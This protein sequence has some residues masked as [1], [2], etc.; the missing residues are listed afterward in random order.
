MGGVL[1]YVRCESEIKTLFDRSMKV[2]RNTL[3]DL[4]GKVT[5]TYN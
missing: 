4:N 1:F 5:Q 2:D 3:P